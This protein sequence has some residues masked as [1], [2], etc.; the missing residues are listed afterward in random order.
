MGDPSWLPSPSADPAADLWAAVLRRLQASEGGSGSAV[1]AAVEPLEVTGGRLQVQVPGIFHRDR[2]AAR[3]LS[4][5]REVL[6]DL[7][8]GLDLEIL[9]DQHTP[10]PPVDQLSLGIEELPPAAGAPARHPFDDRLSF[11]AFV[12]GRSNHLAWSAAKSVAEN[13]ADAY[14]PLFIHGDPGMGKTHLLNAIGLH[15]REH[16]PNAD[17]R[18]VTA[19]RFTNEFIDGVKTTG[20][21]AFKSRYRSA[22]ILRV[23]DVQFLEGKGR[24][25][26]EFFHTLNDITGS[27]GR[28]VITADRHPSEIPAPE[29]LR[30]RFKSGLV[31]DLQAPEFD[32]RVAI[33]RRK[34]VANGAALPNDVLAVIA[35]AVTKNVRELEGALVRVLAEASLQRSPVTV[36]SARHSLHG[37]LGSSGSRPVTLKRIIDEASDLFGV[38]VA[39]LC[40]PSRTRAL[41]NV[42]QVTMYVCRSMTDESLP[43]IGRAFG[44]R[45]HTT[46]INAVRK[47]EARMAERSAVFAMV[48]DLTNRLGGEPPR[49]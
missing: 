6:A 22:E 11:D 38:R 17:V 28:V 18:Y 35:S 5:I 2:L 19:E 27:G 16:L 13:T 46:V 25:Q 8:P 31:A 39:D 14:S 37:F 23:D 41:V 33:L 9:V 40:G 15:V 49:P 45:D 10:S 36:Q 12:V 26:E 47:V 1:L 30:S 42:R 21:D 43:V 20:L 7:A 32:T 29:R 24:T 3:H 48:V 34:A 44:G 4:A